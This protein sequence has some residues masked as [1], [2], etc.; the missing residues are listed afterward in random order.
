MG[1]IFDEFATELAGIVEEDA[2]SLT[3]ERELLS[4]PLWDSMAMVT[5]MAMASDKLDLV[6]E[7]EKL[8]KAVTVGDLYA[9]VAKAPAA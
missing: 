7:P 9:L 2:A 3:S 4:I 8:A 6:I 1:M 5:V